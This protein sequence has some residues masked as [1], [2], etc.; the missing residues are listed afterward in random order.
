VPPSRQARCHRR[1]D[2]SVTRKSCAISLIVTAGEPLRSLQ[3]HLLASSGMLVAE[4][5][6]G[7]ILT[8]VM[9]AMI[10]PPPMVVSTRLARDPEK[11]AREV[12]LAQRD[13]GIK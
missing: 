12:T 1:T 9:I 4:A 5:S 2:P 3:P 10:S 7:A 11:I 13:R 6:G 8:L